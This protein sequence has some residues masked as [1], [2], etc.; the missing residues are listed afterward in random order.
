MDHAFLWNPAIGAGTVR[1]LPS[2]Y[3][4]ANGEQDW[5]RWQGSAV[6]AVNAD[7]NQAASGSH[8]EFRLG[9]AVKAPTVWVNADRC[10]TEGATTHDPFGL[11]A[12]D[13]SSVSSRTLTGTDS[14][15]TSRAA[16]L[17]ARAVKAWKRS[18]HR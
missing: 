6:H 3:A 13:G 1:L 9:R 15:T 7:L 18:N 16:R 2:L 11:Q 8:V 4:H 12:S 10:G 5:R 14:R 17:S